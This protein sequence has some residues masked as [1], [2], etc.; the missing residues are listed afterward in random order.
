[1]IKKAANLF[2]TAYLLIMFCVYPFYMQNGYLDIGEAKNKFFL[3]VSIAGFGI[4]AVIAVICFAGRIKKT[5]RHERDYL[6]DWDGVSAADLFV[7]LYATEVFLSF[8]FTEHKEEA[9]WGTEG[10]YI[11]CIPLLLLCGLYFLISRFWNGGRKIFY[12]VMAASGIVFLLGICN[13]FS[14][15]PI[16]F[17]VVQPDFIS[18]LGN[19]NWFT[20]YLSVIAPVGICLFLFGE[21][22]SDRQYRPD[23]R[24]I[25]Y[26]IYIVT[27]FMA[28]FSQ[29]SSSV[30]LWFAGLFF[31]LVWIAAENSRWMQNL[32]FTVFLWGISAQLVRM[33]RYIFPGKYNYDVNN[34]CGYFTDS[35]LS[36]WISLAGLAVY[37]ILKRKAGKLQS[38]NEKEN[39]SAGKK[40][41]IRKWMLVIVCS[42]ASL[43]LLFAVINTKWELPLFSGNEFFTF[44]RSWGNGRGT[45]FY[46]GIE[47]FKEMPLLH[48]L[49][50]AG[51][52]CF[53]KYAYSIPEIGVMLREE[54]GNSRLANA[55]CE[56][57]TG[58]VNTGVLGIS[59]YVGIF[60]SFIIRN[61]RKGKEN[62]M[63][64]LFAVCAFCYLIH[65]MVSF[66][67]ILNLPFVFLLMG[68]GEK[69][70]REY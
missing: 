38:Q 35:S 41:R 70:L 56:L 36:L 28:G 31:I 27:A 13:R 64:F 19:I 62:P 61:I 9:L 15:Y 20:G 16:A 67:Q 6:I 11:G 63:A 43:F 47:T 40:E 2:T 21:K 69:Y 50:G 8:V 48:K 18:T 42:F 60:A 68:M 7:L 54:F 22:N 24:R 26:G 3:Y 55:H 44:S 37:F 46:A 33:L 59:F 49:F 66:A 58:L 32:F 51:P 34:L 5:I 10:W 57:L 4:L 14:F 30:F 52:D 12:A 39:I 23:F 53:S 17:E 29:G 25:L 65:N 1:M 45:T